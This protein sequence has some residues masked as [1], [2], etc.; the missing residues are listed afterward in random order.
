MSLV[1]DFQGRSDYV[2]VDGFAH[3]GSVTPEEHD[4][5]VDY[6]ENDDQ[7]RTFEGVEYNSF[8]HFFQERIELFELFDANEQDEL[9]YP[10]DRNLDWLLMNVYEV[11]PRR[12]R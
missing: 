8:R 1:F 10:V 6:A 2:I 11:T 5:I 7:P 9:G 3:V 12:T 4:F